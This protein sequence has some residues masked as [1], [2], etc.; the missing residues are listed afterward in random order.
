MMA[1]ESFK[2]SA[3]LELEF[4][5]GVELGQAYHTQDFQDLH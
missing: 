4:H 1:K 5:L 3:L 2:G